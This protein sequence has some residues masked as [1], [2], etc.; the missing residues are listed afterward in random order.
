[1]VSSEWY[2]AIQ[3]GID[4]IV[5]I[6]F[7]PDVRPRQY[8]SWRSGQPESTSQQRTCDAGA[9]HE[10]DARDL[11]GSRTARYL[12]RSGR[13]SSRSTTGHSDRAAQRRGGAAICCAGRTEPM[14]R[15]SIDWHQCI[16]GVIVVSWCQC[17]SADTCGSVSGRVRTS[18]RQ[19]SAAVN[20][21]AGGSEQSL[22]AAARFHPVSGCRDTRETCTASRR[23]RTVAAL[24]GR[25]RRTQSIEPAVYHLREAT[26]WSALR[27]RISILRRPWAFDGSKAIRY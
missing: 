8:G 17:L 23:G 18:W 4:E 22:C 25:Y 5:F 27:V 19:H 21:V 14:H 3:N 24:S 16:G 6:G 15:R 9:R 11:V 1:M 20:V 13:D 10:F 26:L 2:E 7:T 12:E